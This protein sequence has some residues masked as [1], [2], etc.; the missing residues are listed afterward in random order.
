MK[1]A[2]ACGL[3]LGLAT[4]AAGARAEGMDC[5]K[6]P[7]SAPAAA[8]S[9]G[10]CKICLDCNGLTAIE[11][12]R[13]LSQKIGVEV[14]VQGTGFEKLNLKLC[15][16]TP[17]AALDQV[18]RALHAR[19][20]PA[21]IFGTGP[22]A[23]K[24]ISSQR[25]VSVTFRGAPAASAAFLTAAQA[26]GVVISDQTLTGKVTFQGKNVPIS[27]AMDAI[28][29]ASGLTW[30]PAYLLQIGP[31]TLVSRSMDHLRNG[32]SLQVRPGSP[33]THMH[34]SPE[35]MESIA[36]APGMIVTDP[37]A[38]MARLEKESMRRQQLGEWASV[39]TQDT[40]KDTRR[41]ARDLRIRVET[42]IQKLEAYPP[43]N[44][45]LGM[46]MWRAR[47]LRMQ[48]DFKHL[49]PEQQKLVQPVLDAMKFFAPPATP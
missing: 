7:G 12:A 20:H 37:A 26:G 18:A 16:T 41:A 13:Q 42:T 17:E 45:E 44:R 21:Y 35:G 27:R 23:S 36:P 31:D 24:P 46:A 29:A 28:S 15:A 32:G 22:G 1:R 40:P 11:A 49:T 19:W 30:E 6:K 38:E 33:L 8:C 5:C 34:R 3:A 39:F 48:E 4:V 43:Q 14:R 10:S 2:M 47:Y 9:A 25:M